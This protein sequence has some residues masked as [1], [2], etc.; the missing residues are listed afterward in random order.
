MS[1]IAELSAG[2]SD[3]DVLALA[4]A[5]DAVLL[6]A[7]SDFGELVYRQH[8]AHAGVVLLRLSGLTEAEKVGLVLSAVMDHGGEMGGAFSVP[9]P[10]ALRIRA[11]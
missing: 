7:D 2:I 1:Y 6:T 4:R 11:V 9:S 10:R 8:R 3:P 5:S